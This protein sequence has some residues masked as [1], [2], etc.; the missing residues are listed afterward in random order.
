LQLSFDLDLNL[1]SE[2]GALGRDE[3]LKTIIKVRK[4]RTLSSQHCT[5]NMETLNVEL[6]TSNIER[7]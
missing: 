7:L 5:L 6:R 4:I 3:I 2:L 1:L